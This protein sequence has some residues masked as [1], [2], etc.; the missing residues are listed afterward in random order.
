MLEKFK[1]EKLKS[2]MFIIA[3]IAFM[4]LILFGIQAIFM[5]SKPN[6]EKEQK[7]SSGYPHRLYRWD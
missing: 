3:I 7:K 1:A 5:D 4:M 2:T 6:D